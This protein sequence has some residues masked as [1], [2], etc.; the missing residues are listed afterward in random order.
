MTF[1]ARIVCLSAQRATLIALASGIVGFASAPAQAADEFYTFKSV[2]SSPAA[3]W[4]IEVPGA[5]YQAGKRVAIS[6]CSGKPNQVFGYEAGGS[7][8]AGGLCLDSLAAADKAPSAGDP[9]GLSE[10]AGS[11]RQVWELQPFSNKPDVFA[12]AN[13]DGLCVTVDGPA[14]GEGVP[15]ALA[16]CSEL[17]TQGW[18]RGTTASS[19]PEFYYYSGHRYCWYDAGWHGGG[20][21]WCGENFHTGFGWGGPIGWHWWHHHGHKPHWHLKHKLP[22]KPLHKPAL[23][24]HVIHK[25]LV[26]VIHKPAVHVIHKPPVHVMKQGGGTVKHFAPKAQHLK[27]QH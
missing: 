22:F 20:W 11:D 8:T 24:P 14:I 15:L 23:K 7:L 9:V 10:C 19:E 25:P 5:E 18:L 17:D 3:S 27:V 2:L 4:C 26:H 21:Y 12:I 6:A 13:P 1:I 16:Q